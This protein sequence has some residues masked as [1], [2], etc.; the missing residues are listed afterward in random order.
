M[1]KKPLIFLNERCLKLGTLQVID[2]NKQNLGV[3]NS[4]DALNVAREKGLDLLVVSSTVDP[5]IAKI[6]DYGQY[7][8][9]EN[10]RNKG[11]VQHKQETKELKISPRI[12]MHDIDTIVKKAA[13]FLQ[14][15]DKVKITCVF[16]AREVVFPLIGEEKI[17]VILEKLS[18]YGSTTDT[19]ELKGKTMS[20]I[21]SCVKK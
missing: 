21:L 13:A 4:R 16:K 19:I 12:Q 6:L 18:E 3:M 20:V 11:N 17:K 10:K 14:H 15:G 8:Y 7:K 5:P 2:D 9:L 1:N